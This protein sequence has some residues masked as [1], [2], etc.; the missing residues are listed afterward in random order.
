MSDVTVDPAVLA[1]ITTERVVELTKAICGV[2]AP[3]GAEGPLA[4]LLATTLDRPGVE[5]EVDYVLP[6][7]PNVIARVRGNGSG[8]GLLLNGHIDA[9]FYPASGW[10]RDPHDAWVEDGRIYGAAVTDMLGAI[11][12]MTAT[13]EAAAGLDLAGDLVFLASM[14]HDTIGLG[15]KYA[16][17]AEGGWPAY[18]ICAEPSCLEIHTGNG[19]AIKFE[20]DFAG[21][22]AHISRREEGADALAAAVRFASSL[23]GVALD[24]EPHARFPDLP[25]LLVGEL[26]GGIAPGAVAE[27]AVVRGDI[28]TVPGM[29]RESVRLQLQPLID[30][31]CPD[32]VS[33]RLSFL[34][35]QRAYVGPTEGRLVDTLSRA[36]EAVLG[37]PPIV[38]SRLPGQ[39][40][41][42]DAADMQAMG[43]ETLVYG[44]A[45]WVYK[46]DESVPVSELV[47]AARVY[48]ATVLL[49]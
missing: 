3:D 47:D 4:E 7:R 18:G 29:T 12:S 37:S 22:V 35:V 45:D 1:R 27:S 24:H 16:L 32:G 25:C 39:A 48:L 42:T 26:H 2:R 17:A 46:P 38:T 9:S 33:S 30:G 15:V 34:A 8:P 36:H 31:A 14:H 6:G 23:E 11:A 21:R 40:F 13:V 19:G 49:L 10:T 44:P 43:V 28:R 41:V 5:V 20:V